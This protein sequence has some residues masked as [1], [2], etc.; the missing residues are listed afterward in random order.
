MPDS[1]ERRRAA[2]HGIDHPA[3]TNRRDDAALAEGIRRWLVCHR[4]LDDPS[5]TGLDRP[6]A[7]YSSETVVVG[8]GSRV[9]G[10]PSHTLLVFRLAPPAAGTFRDYDLVAQWQA[11]IAAR[12]A[13][14]P[15]ADP[16][17]ET[18]P[19]WLGAPFLVMPRVDGHIVGAVAHLDPWLTGQSRFDQA[20]L[21]RGFLAALSAIHRADVSGAARV[22]RRDNGDELDFW[23]DYLQWSSRGSPVATLVE[24]L[25]WCRRN[26]P[27]TEPEPAL[28]WGDARF[29]N[30]V[31]SDDLRLLAV[32]DWDMSTVGAPE[33]DLAWFTSLDLTVQQLFGTRVDGFPPRDE[34]IS[35]FEEGEGRSAQD[36][37][38]YE[39]LAM[40]RSAAVMT[41]IGYLCLEEGE[42][43]M[44]PIDDN[45]ILDILRGRLQ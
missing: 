24:A 28:L 5:V 27:R 23:E 2:A 12:A 3:L 42:P 21:Y 9:A 30:M 14:V 8:V 45:P 10:V 40:V 6:S 17:L 43:P 22:P 41:R 7:G 38:W 44:L 1:A 18:D 37:E 34:T 11:Q 20:R 25:G 15:V 19:A 32:L 36:L 13:G 31:F 26:R 39:T 16:V 29:E 4:G 33:H 35:L